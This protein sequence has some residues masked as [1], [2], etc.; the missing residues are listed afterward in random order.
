MRLN[1]KDA[2]ATLLVAMVGAIA[3]AHFSNQDWPLVSGTR[4][5][6]VAAFL[7]GVG[8]CAVGARDLNKKQTELGPRDRLIR[9]HGAL[10]FVL[11]V[12]AVIT[13][14]DVALALLVAVIGL[15]WLGATVR[16][17]LGRPSE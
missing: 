6:A 12:A 4:T 17:L 7:L 8:A 13:R 16:H 3:W 1:A 10:A 9:A 5:V 2:I 15:A 14:N 11:M